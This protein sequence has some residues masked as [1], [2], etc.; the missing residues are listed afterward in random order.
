[1]PAGTQAGRQAARQAEVS[2]TRSQTSDKRCGVLEH[3]RAQ[4]VN[5]QG[6]ALGQLEGACR[7]AQ[8]VTTA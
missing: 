5:W 6:V 7:K 8:A 3:I 1:M 4:R 2:K